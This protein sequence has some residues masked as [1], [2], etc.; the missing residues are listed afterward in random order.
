MSSRPITPQDLERLKAEI[1][2]EIL[3][4]LKLKPRPEPKE[5][6]KSYE[7]KKLL[8]VSAGKLQNMRDQGIISFTRLGGLLLYSYQDIIN[9]LESHKHTLHGNDKQY[10]KKR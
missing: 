8:G 7:V 2:Q 3:R 6:L 1:V 9:L 10:K 4:V 5:W